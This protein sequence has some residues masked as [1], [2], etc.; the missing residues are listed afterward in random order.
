LHDPDDP[1]SLLPNQQGP[2]M[3]DTT[4]PFTVSEI[5]TTLDQDLDGTMPRVISVTD[6]SQ[7]PDSQGNI[8]INYGTDIQEGPIPYIARP[9][10]TTLLISPAY[11]IQN[12]HPAGSDIAL[13]DS[14]SPPN[15]TR[16]GTDYPFYVTD[17]VSGRLYAQ[18]L[19][20]SVAATGINIVFTVLYPSDIGLG[21]WGTEFSENPTI[22]GE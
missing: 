6:A 4:Q 22:W 9:S 2:Y 10:S 3:F 8:I 7:F 15:I 12:S 5:G 13:V 11:T 1:Q 21:K 19:I 17:V 14:K 20:N 16:D 18:D